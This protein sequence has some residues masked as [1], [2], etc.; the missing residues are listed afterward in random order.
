MAN[1]T[2]VIEKPQKTSEKKIT[3]RAPLSIYENDRQ[4]TVL[5]ALPGV[6]ET[7]MQVTVKDNKLT[8][9]APLKISVP[10]SSEERYSEM[11]LADY[12]RT[13][14]LGD[15]VDE[16]NIEATF[17]SGVLQLTLLKSKRNPSKKIVVKTK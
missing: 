4:Y 8:V 15:L 17:C 12:T 2:A 7:K 14:E 3:L 13:V 6:D 11:L 16:E 10:P 1:Y 5:L 9:D